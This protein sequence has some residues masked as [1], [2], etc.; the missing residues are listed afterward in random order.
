MIAFM[1]PRAISA[2]RT[3]VFMTERDVSTLWAS[4]ST[5]LRDIV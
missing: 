2:I 4:A 3:M 1:I 5:A